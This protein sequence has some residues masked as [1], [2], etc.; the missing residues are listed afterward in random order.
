[1]PGSVTFAGA[2]A[3]DQKADEHSDTGGNGDGF[4][5]MFMHG[6]IGSFRACD[7]F[8][9]DI[10]RDFL[11]TFQRIGETLA[12]IPDLFS[13]H[14]GSSRHQ[15]ASIFCERVNVVTGCMFMFFHIVLFFL[16]LLCYSEKL[17][18]EHFCNDKDDEGSEKASAS[19]EINQGIASGGKNGMDY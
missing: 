11:D 2:P 13:S 16:F 1:M 8:V 15:R 10:A 12:G 5:R 19:K 14:V 4:I 7:R 18:A 6:F 17:F 9:P 3:G